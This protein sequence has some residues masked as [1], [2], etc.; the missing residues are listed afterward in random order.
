[1]KIYFA[2]G[3][4]IFGLKYN[5]KFKIKNYLDSYFSLK[6]KSQIKLFSKN[7]KNKKSNNYEK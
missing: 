1:M 6:N 3:E 2:G 7:N 4:D 5:L